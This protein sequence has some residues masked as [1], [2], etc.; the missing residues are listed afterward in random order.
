MMICKIVAPVLTA[1]RLRSF[2]AYYKPHGKN[3]VKVFERRIDNAPQESIRKIKSMQVY[4]NQ[5]EIE[6]A[7]SIKSLN[8]KDFSIKIHHLLVGK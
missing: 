7:E 5:S 3:K 4:E 2:M 6:L 1:L 8:L